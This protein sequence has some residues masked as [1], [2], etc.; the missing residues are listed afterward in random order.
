MLDDGNVRHL[1]RRRGSVPMLLVRGRVGND[2]A[3]PNLLDLAPP[4]LHPAGA[5]RHDQRLAERVRVPHR[6]A[7]GSNVHARNGNSR[8]LPGREQSVDARRAGEES[9]R[10]AGGGLLRT[11]LDHDRLQG[12]GIGCLGS[13]R[14]IGAPRL[15]G[16]GRPPR[17]A[18]ESGPPPRRAAPFLGDSPRPQ[19][20]SPEP[21]SEVNYPP[22]HVN[23]P[24]IRPLARIV[25]R[26]SAFCYSGKPAPG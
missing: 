12:V 7:P 6:P 18:S 10:L 3:C 16:P 2:V 20:A 23:P 8:R 17:R 4:P 25:R 19:G 13:G 1:R 14:I 11:S 21:R 22:E 24:V 26:V 15:E 9:P 5:F